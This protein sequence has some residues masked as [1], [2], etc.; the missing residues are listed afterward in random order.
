MC[1]CVLVC[2][3]ACVCVCVCVCLLVCVR[4]CVCT[5][6]ACVCVSGKSTKFYK[7][8]S[9]G[10]SVSYLSIAVSMKCFVTLAQ[11]STLALC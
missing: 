4:A 5:F 11:V 7:Y 6:T 8:V 10:L 1:V 2:V 9:P 3:C